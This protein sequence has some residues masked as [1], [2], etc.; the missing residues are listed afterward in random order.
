MSVSRHRKEA[1]KRLGL[2]LEQRYRNLV[3]ASGPDEVTV[4]AVD[5]GQVFND[6]IEFVIW[7]LKT[8]GGLIPPHPEKLKKDLGTP[9][10]L[11]TLPDS[12]TKLIR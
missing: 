2:A 6:N 12:L 4:A 9:K 10:P 1:S 7:V 8:Y 5:L 11:P 3:L